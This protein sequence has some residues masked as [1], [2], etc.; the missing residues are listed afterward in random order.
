[1]PKDKII[2]KNIL[3][4]LQQIIHHIVIILTDAKHWRYI[5]NSSKAHIRLKHKEA[6]AGLAKPKGK[7]NLWGTSNKR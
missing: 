4:F 5:F 7:Y 6:F 1:M 3:S 2:E